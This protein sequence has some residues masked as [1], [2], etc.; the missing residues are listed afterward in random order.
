ISSESPKDWC[1]WDLS[2]EPL[3]SVKDFGFFLTAARRFSMSPF[4]LVFCS[5]SLDIAITKQRF[6]TISE[7]PFPFFISRFDQTLKILRDIAR[8]FHQLFVSNTY[9]I[10]FR[11]KNKARRDKNVHFCIVIDQLHRAE[12]FANAGNVS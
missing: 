9:Q 2:K 10:F 5:D 6:K 8:P 3:S 1:V 12:E 11:V 4:K 7:I